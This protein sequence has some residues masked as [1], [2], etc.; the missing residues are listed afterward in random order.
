MASLYEL[1]GEFLQFSDTAFQ[2]ELTEEQS[3]MMKEALDNLK[4]DIEFKLDGY[5]K[6]IKNFEAD[7]AGLKAEEERLA[8]RRKTLENR[9]KTM[10]E[11]M[12]SAILA[13]K[14]DEPKIKT[15]LFSFAVQNNAPSVV[16]D[17]QYIENIPTE[18]LKFAEPEIN[19]KKLA[20]DLKAGVAPEGI[21]H[22]ETSSSLRIR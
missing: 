13:V 22:L 19:K 21:A 3:E 7:I 1:T 10:K 12:K 6:V 9:I 17:E 18:Y 8:N 2:S 11:A 20:E 5:C 4:E 16:I 15:A 14:P